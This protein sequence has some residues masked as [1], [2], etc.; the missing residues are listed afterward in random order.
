MAREVNVQEMD[1][2]SDEEAEDNLRYLRERGRTQE[3]QAVVD[4]FGDRINVN[5]V[6]PWENEGVV[7]AD[8]EVEESSWEDY[9]VEQLREELEARGLPKS[10]NKDELIARL[11][12]SD[13][14]E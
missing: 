7:E 2:W 5:V 1:D 3:A 11:E 12:E 9:T 8:E 4:K 6:T 14:G 13:E 10:G